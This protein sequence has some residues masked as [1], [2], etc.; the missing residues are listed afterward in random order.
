MLQ[1]YFHLIF[2]FSSHKI[3]LIITCPF[4]SI[5][6][7]NPAFS[8]NLT[9]PVKSYSS[10]TSDILAYPSTAK[11]TSKS[12]RKR[13]QRF[14]GNKTMLRISFQSGLEPR[15]KRRSPPHLRYAKKWRISSV[16]LYYFKAFKITSVIIGV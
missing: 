16:L 13:L 9:G 3:F 15:L 8:Y 2:L 10:L 14:L 11:H 1:H 4:C 12:P 7:I 5:I 6:L